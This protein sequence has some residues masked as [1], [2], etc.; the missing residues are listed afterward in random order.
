V[1][2]GPAQAAAQAVP[3]VHFTIDGRE[4]VV[5]KGTTVWQAARQVGIEIPI[6]CYH[7]RMPP[8]GACRMCLVEVEKMPKLMT[9]C[10][11]EAGEDMVVRSQTSRVK[12]GQ[13]AMLEFLLVN[14][15]LDCP[16]C[17]KG[18]E[19]PLQDNTLKFGPGPC[20]RPSGTCASFR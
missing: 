10:T 1:S 14:H 6:F 11:L 5:P 20:G 18:G 4:V 17:D 16:I 15:P 7:D 2:S 12:E 3:M 19:C 13:R 9:S 8:L